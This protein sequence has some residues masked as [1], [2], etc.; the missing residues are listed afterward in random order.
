MPYNTQRA[1]FCGLF[2][3]D[4]WLGVTTASIPSVSSPGDLRSLR[5]LDGEMVFQL[6]NSNQ[7]EK[8]SMFAA[9]KK[10]LKYNGIFVRDVLRVTRAR[11]VIC[12]YDIRS[13]LHT[14][15]VT[16]NLLQ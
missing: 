14:T 9:P 8:K 2:C 10:P 5:S 13:G 4:E 15:H 12:R 11:S 6:T 3:N 1:P 7:S 16:P